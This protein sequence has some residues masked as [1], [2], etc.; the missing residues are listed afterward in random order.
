MSKE[1]RTNLKK[2][3]KV[4]CNTILRNSEHRKSFNSRDLITKVLSK[5]GFKMLQNLLPHFNINPITRCNY[6]SKSSPCTVHSNS[7]SNNL[8]NKP[9]QKDVNKEVR[10]TKRPNRPNHSVINYSFWK[11]LKIQLIFGATKPVTTNIGNN[12]ELVAENSI[13]YFT[14]NKKS[15]IY[16]HIL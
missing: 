13:L 9:L 10:C 16:I 15:N 2:Y 12:G 1:N 14:E 5:F 7:E 3:K 11:R 8:F 6:F 4:T